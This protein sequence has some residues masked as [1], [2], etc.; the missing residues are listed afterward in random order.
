MSFTFSS[1]VFFDEFDPNGHLHNAR[2]AVHA[3][4]AQTAYFEQLGFAGDDLHYV[5]RELHV[6]FLAPV[7]TTGLLPVTLTGLKIGRTSAVYGFTCGSDPVHAHGHRVVVKIDRTTGRPIPWSD[8]YRDA[9]A[10]L[11]A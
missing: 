10:G 4:R 11:A 2:F 1:P 3:E 7:G 8:G 9:F 6:E 5:V